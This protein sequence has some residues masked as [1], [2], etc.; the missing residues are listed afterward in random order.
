[1]GNSRKIAAILNFFLWGFGY[2]YL[3][4]RKAFGAGMFIVEIL[5]HAPIIFLNAS[6]WWSWPFVLYPASHLLIGIL[7]A[8]DAYK[9]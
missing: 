5:E 2:L 4:K 6:T 9:G 7:L 8:Y 3:G 1:M